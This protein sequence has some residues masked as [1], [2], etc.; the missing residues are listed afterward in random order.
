M[1][2]KV[3]SLRDS[4][5]WAFVAYDKLNKKYLGWETDRD[6]LTY[7]IE[8]NYELMWE[9]DLIEILPVDYHTF[10]ALIQEGELPD[11]SV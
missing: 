2:Y 3:Y 6:M 9:Q 4:T 8:E 1:S 11:E 5:A 7:W 10:V